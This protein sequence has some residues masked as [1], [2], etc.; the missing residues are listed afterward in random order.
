MWIL[1]NSLKHESAELFLVNTLY[2]LVSQCRFLFLL[3]GRQHTLHRMY[4][5]NLKN[6][7]CMHNSGYVISN[8]L[9]GVVGIT[10]K[11]FFVHVTCQDLPAKSQATSDP[12][13][14]WYS[15]LSLERFHQALARSVQVSTDKKAWKLHRIERCTINFVCSSPGL[16]IATVS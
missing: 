9:T 16:L 3:N 11:L 15:H 14:L 8:S 13:Q 6:N 7:N 5:K 2:T 1:K 4:E 12:I 10:W